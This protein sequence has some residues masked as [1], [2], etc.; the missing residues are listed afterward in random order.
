MSIASCPKKYGLEMRFS[1]RL[2]NQGTRAYPAFKIVELAARINVVDVRRAVE[3]DSLDSASTQKSVI[4]VFGRGRIV[5]RAAGTFRV[6]SI[7]LLRSAI[8]LASVPSALVT[9]IV[10]K[11]AGPSSRGPAFR[12]P[13]TTFMGG[14]RTSLCSQGHLWWDR[15]CQR[16]HPRIPCHQYIQF[17]SVHHT[18]A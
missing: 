5:R 4:S 17:W 14:A 11:R 10:K 9:G 1:A 7:V 8:S 18:V 3:A 13:K 6:C 15:N 2:V 16:Y 12:I